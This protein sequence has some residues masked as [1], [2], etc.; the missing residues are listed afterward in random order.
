MQAF[1]V[2]QRGR[3]EYSPIQTLIKSVPSTSTA[4]QVGTGLIALRDGEE[5][6]P[7]LDGVFGLRRDEPRLAEDEPTDPDAL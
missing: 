5:H 3:I 4:D 1:V 6:P 7:E 2:D